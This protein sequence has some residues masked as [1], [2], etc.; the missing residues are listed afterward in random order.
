MSRLS[1]V[2]ADHEADMGGGPL[3][4]TSGAGLF[5]EWQP[6]YAEHGIA[7]FP[8]CEKRPA[9]SGYL[10]MGLPASQQ[11]ALKFS[12][13][14]A[15]GLACKRS[16]ITVLD[17]DAPDERLLADGLA[18]FGPTPFIVRSG[19]GNFQAWYRHSGEGRRVRPDPRRPIDILGD[20][21]VVAPP[22]LGLR[23]RYTIIE[24]TLD[25]LDRL[26][27]MRRPSIPEVASEAIQRFQTGTRNEK[28]W[29]SCM[30]SA[31]GCL[32]ITDLM[33]GAVEMN[34]AMFYEPL[35][36]DEVL[37]IVA[38]AWAKEISGENWFGRGGRVI[39]DAEDVDKLGRGH[40]DAL[41]LLTFLKRHH[42][43]PQ[44]F[45]I[46]NAW[47]ESIGM[48]RKRFAT[49]RSHLLEVGVI[50]QVRAASRQ[51]GP[52]LYRFKGGQN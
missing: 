43:G 30:A 22:S 12:A 15:F 20:G 9:V 40:P 24:G 28:L 6:R 46:A 3:K 49:A 19:S 13:A 47:A 31:R 33:K 29:R 18:Q 41:I 51:R 2:G 50:E 35:A 32:D 16:G 11:L 42:W 39:L 38:S 1:E 45:V 4:A 23:G 7:T 48:P 26:P 5:A 37:K 10:K 17:V 36:N 8:V 21:F 27:R 44:P 14:N 52:A 25:D 34:H